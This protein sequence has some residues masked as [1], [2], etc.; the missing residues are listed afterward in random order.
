MFWPEVLFIYQVC[1][2]PHAVTTEHMV[3]NPQGMTMIFGRQE[4]LAC[5]LE[6]SNITDCPKRQR[7]DHKK[8]PWV[9]SLPCWR[10]ASPSR[11]SIEATF[12]GSKISPFDEI[13]I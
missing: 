4:I 10:N 1:I 6:H 7:D 12:K 11:P 3:Q 8:I 2:V 13:D 9:R 5:T